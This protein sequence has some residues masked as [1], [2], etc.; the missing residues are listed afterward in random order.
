[1]PDVPPTTGIARHGDLG[2][3]P[4]MVGLSPACPS[5][6]WLRGRMVCGDLGAIPSPKF[7]PGTFGCTDR[8]GT[9]SAEPAPMTATPAL[10]MPRPSENATA[11]RPQ[12]RPTKTRSDRYNASRYSAYQGDTTCATNANCLQSRKKRT[13]ST[14]TSKLPIWVRDMPAA[15]GFARP[16]RHRRRVLFETTGPRSKPLPDAIWQ[17]APPGRS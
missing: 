17:T 7:A 10:A 8:G 6:G 12:W 16:A 9:L 1:M 13:I 15:S 11:V 14:S 3:L 2:T 5:R 4:A